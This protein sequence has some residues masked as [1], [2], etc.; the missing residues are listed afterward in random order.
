MNTS[1]QDYAS[2]LRQITHALAVGKNDLIAGEISRRDSVEQVRMFTSGNL[3]KRFDKLK[4]QLE[5]LEDEIPELETLIEDY[6]LNQPLQAYDTGT[7][8]TSSFMKWLSGRQ[9]LTPEQRDLTIVIRSRTAILEIGRR[10][11]MA[12]VRFQELRSLVADLAR[13]L[14]ENP[15]LR[16][17]LNPVCLWVAFESSL[18]LEDDADGVNPGGE[19]LFYAYENEVRTAVLEDAARTVMWTLGECQPCS[20]E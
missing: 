9:A 17:L 7:S 14:G 8:D 19:A 20:L 1:H 5:L 2:R 16:I 6:V 11:R 12:H 18:L 4:D 3:E 15:S 13:E 10:N